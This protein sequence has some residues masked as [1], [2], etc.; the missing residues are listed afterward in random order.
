[1]NH[2]DTE[3]TNKSWN[4]SGRFMVCVSVVSPLLMRRYFPALA[5]QQLNRAIMPYQI[6]VGKTTT[7]LTTCHR[8]LGNHLGYGTE[9]VIMARNS[10][11]LKEK[12]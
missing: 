10:D 7:Q 2:G 9:H 11:L 4:N 5:C 12:S 8:L 1:L 3:S 6:E